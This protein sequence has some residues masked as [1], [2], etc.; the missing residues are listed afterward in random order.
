MVIALA[1]P[2]A[3]Q[4]AV[5]EMRCLGRRR[6]SNVDRYFKS[7]RAILAE[8]G[9]SAIEFDADLRGGR[10]IDLDQRIRAELDRILRASQQKHA[11]TRYYFHFR[12]GS[13]FEDEIGEE[14]SDVES[15]RRYARRVAS[16]L[17]ED[18]L[19]RDSSIV[20]TE[21]GRHLF[22]IALPKSA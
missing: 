7:A 1:P 4:A 2:C 11:M 8:K 17:A 13:L 15:A 3:A 5:A 10:Q 16:E 22:D 21:N 6:V 19:D 18:G 12:N 20:V 9:R 14:F